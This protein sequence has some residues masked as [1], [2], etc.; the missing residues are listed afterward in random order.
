MGDLMV[1]QAHERKNKRKY[2]AGEVEAVAGKKGENRIFC[3]R[4]GT[5]FSGRVRSWKI[6]TEISTIGPGRLAEDT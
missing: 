4:Q 5:H 3:T 1:I 2:S 6:C